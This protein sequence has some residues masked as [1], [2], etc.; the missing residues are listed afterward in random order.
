MIYLLDQ[1]LTEKSH[2]KF[3]IDILREHTDNEIKLIEIPNNPTYTQ[4]YKILQDLYSI[5]RPLDVVLC[6]W[7]VDADFHLDEMF[8]EL[9]D[10]CHVIVAAGNFNEDIEKYSPARAEK[11]ITV[12]CLNKS[13][14]KATHS[15]WSNNKNLVWVKGTNYSVGW[16][17]SSG[18]SVSAAVY[19][20][21]FSE[22]LK[23]SDINIIDNLLNAFHER[24]SLI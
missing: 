11:V 5:V 7:A 23:N 20:A 9:S 21:F 24:T 6:P 17:N 8:N 19:A 14:T 10:L 1:Q 15:N 16:K 22:A 2:S 13:G 12:A 18:T 4:L 3:V